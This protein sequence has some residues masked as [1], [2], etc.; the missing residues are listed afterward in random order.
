MLESDIQS[1]HSGQMEPL[2]E[3]FLFY[4]EEATDPS[5][6]ASTIVLFRSLIELSPIVR[7]FVLFHSAIRTVHQWFEPFTN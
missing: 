2:T 5:I 4:E 7:T 6:S 1:L 3:D